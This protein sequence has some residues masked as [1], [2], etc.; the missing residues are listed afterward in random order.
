LPGGTEEIHEILKSEDPV[1]GLR[2]EFGT[3]RMGRRSV[4]HATTTFDVIL[5]DHVV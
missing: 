5:V 2:F 1:S 4:K 3:S